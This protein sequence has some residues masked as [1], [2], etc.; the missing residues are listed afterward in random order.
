[1]PVLAPVVPLVLV[2]ILVL[3]TDLGLQ[4]HTQPRMAAAAAAAPPPRRGLVCIGSAAPPWCKY[5]H[6]DPAGYSWYRLSGKWQLPDICLS[7]A[8][9]PTV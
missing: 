6:M 1:M 7:T 9:W 2:V 5:S 4:E 8:S 3:D